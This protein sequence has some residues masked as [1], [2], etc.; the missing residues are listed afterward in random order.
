V[1]LVCSSSSSSSTVFA[2]G[3]CLWS[4]A[5]VVGQQEAGQFCELQLRIGAVRTIGAVEE[6]HRS[7]GGGPLDGLFPS[8]DPSPNDCLGLSSLSRTHF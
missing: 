8:Q 5:A 4:G 6:D 2:F 7:R 1:L 3:G